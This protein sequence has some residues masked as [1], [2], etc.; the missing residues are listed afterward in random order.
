[1]N[2]LRQ[3]SNI[4]DRR[5]RKPGRYDTY[6][7]MEAGLS[8]RGKGEI[9]GAVPTTLHSGYS[10]FQNM[11]LVWREMKRPADIFV[12]WEGHLSVFGEDS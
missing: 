6:L 4:L 2:I 3:K 1:M 11:G 7:C 5:V 12:Y 9:S 8:G 10:T